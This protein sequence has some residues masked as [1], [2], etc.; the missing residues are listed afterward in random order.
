MAARIPSDRAWRHFRFGW[1]TLLVFL[2]MGA[3]LELF[4][5]F[6]VEWYLDVGYE[7]RRLMWRLAHAHGALLGLVNV[8]F[9]ST[10]QLTGRPSGRSGEWA[11]HCLIAATVVLPG[12]FF[13]GGASVYGGDPGL[14]VVVAP[15]GA[16]FLFVSVAL[17]ARGLGPASEP[18]EAGD[19]D[20]PGP[21][22]GDG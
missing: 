16:V 12:G 13:L 19:G 3:I 1:W 8:V 11:S 22:P 10:L 9:A 17:V 5:A 21:E 14:G 20:G 15:V 4:H 7:T 6:K 18:E 2:S